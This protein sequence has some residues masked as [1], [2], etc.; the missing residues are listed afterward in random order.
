MS[1]QNMN[2]VSAAL[3]A[4]ADSLIHQRAEYTAQQRAASI[5]VLSEGAVTLDETQVAAL[6]DTIKEKL[7]QHVHD[8]EF[9]RF[10]DILNPPMQTVE[11]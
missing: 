7:Y 9:A 3:F 10:T 11:R 6:R 4:A 2:A 1:L 8:R 5:A